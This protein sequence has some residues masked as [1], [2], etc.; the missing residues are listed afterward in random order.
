VTW[1]G[2]KRGS[3]SHRKTIQAGP[4]RKTGVT[5]ISVRPPTAHS[6][7]RQ[8]HRPTEGTTL[9][10]DDMS[11]RGGG[12]GLGR[13]EKPSADRRDNYFFPGRGGKQ[14]NYSRGGRHSGKQTSTAKKVRRLTK[15]RKESGALPPCEKGVPSLMGTHAKWGRTGVEG[16]PEWQSLHVGG[17]ILTQG[18]LTEKKKLNQR[19]RLSEGVASTRRCEKKK[20]RRT[21][22]PGTSKKVEANRYSS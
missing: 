22:S 17:A 4:P 16:N 11:P 5:E 10:Q 6:V 13:K 15:R 3:T 21:C 18:K 1:R 8:A 12:V 9:K 19:T 2:W 14:T 20:W 7:Q